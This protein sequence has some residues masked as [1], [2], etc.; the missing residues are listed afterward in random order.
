[1]V[2]VMD[3]SNLSWSM[4]CHSSK[5]LSMKFPVATSKWLEVFY[6]FIFIFLSGLKLTFA[7][8]LVSCKSSYIDAIEHKVGIV[9]ILFEGPSWSVRREEGSEDLRQQQQQTFF[10]PQATKSINNN[11]T[12][13]KK[14]SEDHSHSNWRRSL[15]WPNRFHQI[16]LISVNTIFYI[17]FIYHAWLRTQYF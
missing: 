5:A 10:T 9:E 12:E 13:K 1:M 17:N 3:S 2:W 11:W 6:F 15:K 7:L 8:T 4:K 16:F 14:G